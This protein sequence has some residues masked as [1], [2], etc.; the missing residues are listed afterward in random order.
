MLFSER[1]GG[2]DGRGIRQAHSC[3]D[4]QAPGETQETLFTKLALLVR[5][6]ITTL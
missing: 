5:D 3:P 2:H 4:S 6:H 1:A